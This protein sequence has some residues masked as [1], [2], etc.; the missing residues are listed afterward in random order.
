[1]S[2][3]LIVDGNQ[4]H[5]E[6]LG[7]AMLG[8]GFRVSLAHT[9][10]EGFAIGADEEI[11]VV[12]LADD[13]ADGDGAEPLHR[14][15]GG[16]GAPEVIVLAEKGDGGAAARAIK[17]GAWD[18]IP[19]NGAAATLIE[20]L[21]C[22]ADYR[23]R[24]KAAAGDDQGENPFVAIVG[25][26]SRLRMCIDLL[27]RAATSDANVLLQGE[28]GTGKEKFAVALHRASPR[29]GKNFVVVDCAALP[30]T[31]VESTLFGHERG[32]FTGATRNA[33][34]LI[35]QAD[36]GTL[37]LDEVGELPLCLQKSFLR[38]LEER[39]FRPVGGEKEQSSD[40]RL[41][42][43][44]NQDLDALVAAGRFRSDLLFRL[45]TFA[46][47][48]PSLRE[49]KEDM[50]PLA[51]HFLEQ[52][53]DH[54]RI[55][56]KAVSRGF[57]AALDQYDWPGNVRELFHALE[58]ALAA[59]GDE[60]VLLARHLPIHI[61]V[62]NAHAGRAAAAAQGG[63]TM[64]C[65][66]AGG[67]RMTGKTLQQVRDEVLARVENRYLQQLLASTGGRIQP[68]CQISGLSRSRLYQLLKDHNIRSAA[69]C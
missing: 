60:P 4:A 14:F 53:C 23:R 11:D 65:P 44:T 49:R 20:A 8:K 47:E 67:L 34:G 55:P 28:T 54:H 2:H 39:R 31:L 35:K 27:G 52:Y 21:L 26:S 5:C 22:L 59:A 66:A 68:A 19:K 45:R 36:G 33:V 15:R 42:A 48:L 69:A 32:A 58:R 30:E 63:D 51:G 38:V 46:I 16:P 12:L 41:V 62:E 40:F 50:E 17:G 25:N 9:L 43:A 64:A 7:T 1:M 24:G 57:F 3:I 29:H 37:F 56:A 6:R 61:R 13:L 10:Q 18:Y